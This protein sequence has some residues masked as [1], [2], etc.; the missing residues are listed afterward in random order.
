MV[1]VPSSLTSINSNP[2]IARPLS[3]TYSVSLI[4]LF[5]L[6]WSRVDC[7]L[8]DNQSVESIIHYKMP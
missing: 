2:F 6:V 4:N 7:Q 8:T 3:T 5:N 1:A